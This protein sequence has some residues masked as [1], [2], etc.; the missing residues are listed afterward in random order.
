M[1]SFDTTSGA[2]TLTPATPSVTVTAKGLASG[3][4][5]SAVKSAILSALPPIVQAACNQAQPT[6]A[7]MSTRTQGL[8]QQLQTL[9]AKAA[10][11]LDSANFSAD[12]IALLGTVALSPRSPPTVKFAK[13]GDA[14]NALESW[15]PG[16]RIDKFEWSWSW[17]AHASQ[18]P[19]GSATLGR[20]VLALVVLRERRVV[21]GM[22]IGAATPLP[23]LDGVGSVCLKIVGVRVDPASGA[24]V[25]VQTT[26]HCTRYGL[27]LGG[28]VRQADRLFVRDFTHGGARQRVA[29]L[30]LVSLGTSSSNG[31]GSNTLVVLP[32]KRVDER[33]AAAIEQ[34]LV[35]CRRHD[36][37]LSLLVLFDE[38]VLEAGSHTTTAPVQA[39]GEK[40]GISVDVNE[41]VH[42]GWSKAFGRDGGTLFAIITPDGVPVW[43]HKGTHDASTLASALDFHLK[44]SLDS[45]PRPYGVAEF[46]GRSLESRC[47]GA[48]VRFARSALPAGS[49]WCAG[50]C[51]RFGDRVC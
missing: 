39:I 33:E 1:L 51:R 7:G 12:G 37:G 17:S 14:F 6:L 22:S 24:L 4:V 30:P 28:P 26:V 40:L 34:G 2:L 38:G 18:L 31:G 50:P 16:G 15:I 36:A 43:T 5:A 44:A 47:A 46:R 41:D 8:A 3:T 21:R 48:S 32:G 23:G 29:D 20:S 10:V 25:P 13:M 35:R 27:N 49:D 42:G 11:S 9:D 19:P 45:T